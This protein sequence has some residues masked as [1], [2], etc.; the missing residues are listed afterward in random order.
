[1]GWFLETLL[2]GMALLGCYA[3]HVGVDVD[4][5]AY[6]LHHPMACSCPAPCTILRPVAVRQFDR[7]SYQA[8]SCPIA[9]V[10]DGA[11]LRM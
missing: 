1:M 4:G 8:P 5:L 7:A 10:G 11:F 3:S 2:H 6:T 9:A